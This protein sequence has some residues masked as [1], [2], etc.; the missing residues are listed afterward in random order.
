M[1]WDWG[2]AAVGIAAIAVFAL[3]FQYSGLVERSLAAMAVARDTMAIIG[4][5]SLDDDEKE[6]LVQ[7]AAIRLL[8]YFAVLTL[9]SLLVLAAPALL[10]WLGQLA[11]IAS[12]AAVSDFLLSWQVIVGATVLMIA[13]IW[14]A[15]RL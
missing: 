2:V 9:I 6:P 4:D 1:P 3:A 7:K 11:G 13:V 8:G 5:K 15:R 12:F 10:M 14:I